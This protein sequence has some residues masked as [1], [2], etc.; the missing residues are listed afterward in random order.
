MLHV[1]FKNSKQ[2]AEMLNA[3]GDNA[4]TIAQTML[5]RSGVFYVGDVR[6]K[7]FGSSTGPNKLK[8]RSGML[9]QAIDVKTVGTTLNTLSLIITFDT[10]YAM[11]QE[12]GDENRRP[13]HAQYLAIPLPAA[14]TRAGV[15]RWA[16]PLRQSDM[17]PVRVLK[18]KKGNLLL[19]D[20]ATGQ[21]YFVLK[22]QVKIPPRL[23]AWALLQEHLP[24]IQNDLVEGLIHQGFLNTLVPK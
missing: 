17:P 19:V 12:F 3:A 9:R 8:V 24:N 23:G 13:K 4:F 15:T 14:Q 10:N 18:S 2:V 7:R 20:K 22:T 1:L 21:P 5:L 11:T 6:V 16:S